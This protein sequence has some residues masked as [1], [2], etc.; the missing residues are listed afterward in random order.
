MIGRLCG[1]LV[2]HN[3]DGSILVDV[4][5]VAY[6]LFVPIGSLGHAP[7]TEDRVTLSVHTHVRPEAITLYGFASAEERLAFRS[8]LSVSSI[9]PKL[10][11]SILGRLD[12][13]SLSLA[14]AR[15]DK[16][17]F[18]GI[19]GVGK[20]TVERLF[21]DLKDKLQVNGKHPATAEAI[22][23]SAPVPES[24]SAIRALVQMGYKQGEAQS[25]VHQITGIN[26]KSDVESIL[27]AAL[28]SL[29]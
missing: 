29:S 19:S 23:T 25:A 21:I 14:V 27:R 7:R 12:A 24:E 11:I 1:E 28:V 10:A 26:P 2:E 8:L 5:G 15:Q 13:Q 22:H 20:K 9:G 16:A 4:Q 3:D 6:E 18:K 17:A